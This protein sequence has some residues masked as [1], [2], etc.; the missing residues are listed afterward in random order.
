MTEIHKALVAL[1]YN[2][3]GFVVKTAKTTT[4]LTLHKYVF[5]VKTAYVEF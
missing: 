4:K 5:N 1:I 2:R 3:N